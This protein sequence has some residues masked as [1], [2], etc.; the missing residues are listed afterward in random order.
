MPSSKFIIAGLLAFAALGASAQTF[1]SDAWVRGTVAGQTSTG[2]FGN[3]TSTGGGKLV[4]AWTPLAARTELHEMSM[5]GDVMKMRPIDA[6]P[7][8][9]GQTV[10]L[11][12]G[13]LHVMLLGLKQPMRPGETVPLTLVVLD[14]G[15]NRT[16]VQVKVP[17][18]ALDGR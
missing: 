9:S 6:V 4:Q 2:L 10:E 15:G 18:R 7:L 8:P 11:K 16:E 17:V 3:I 12:P 13:G 1:V 5:E 14:P